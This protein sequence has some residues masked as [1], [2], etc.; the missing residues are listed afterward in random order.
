MFNVCVDWSGS[1]VFYCICTGVIQCEV[2][3]TL[4]ILFSW[5]KKFLWQQSEIWD[6]NSV[7][8]LL[9]HPSEYLSHHWSKTLRKNVNKL[10]GSP[11]N[12][13]K[14]EERIG[15]VVSTSHWI[16]PVIWVKN[17]DLSCKYYS[18]TQFLAAL[19][20]NNVDI[21]YKRWS[22]IEVLS[23]SFDQFLGVKTISIIFLFQ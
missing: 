23:T 17:S 7:E 14:K 18:S 3:T 20:N 13:E 10:S 12:S 9:G 22:F 19:N 2:L 21:F 1:S 16:R 15:N 11:R 4:P 8:K 6:D 5:I